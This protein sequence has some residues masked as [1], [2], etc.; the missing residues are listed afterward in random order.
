M[1]RWFYFGAMVAGTLLPLSQFLPWLSEN[2]LDIPLFFAELFANPISGFFGWDVIVSALVLIPF[3][4][5][6][7]KRLGMA[8][9]WMPVAGTFLIGVSCGLPMFLYLREARL[10]QMKGIAVNKLV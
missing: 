9:L 5:I 8:R 6:E 3:I 1:L 10:E 7:G 2:G 4:L